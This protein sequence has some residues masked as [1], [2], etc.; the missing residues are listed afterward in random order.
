MEQ[1][2]EHFRPQSYNLELSISRQKEKI[3][4]KVEIRGFVER[5][6]SVIK[7]H[8]VNL[9]IKSLKLILENHSD[10]EF[11]ERPY[12]YDGEVLIIPLDHAVP[13]SSEVTV[14]IDYETKLNHNMQGCYL[15]TYEWQGEEQRIVA[16][17]FESH[18]AREA[19]PCIDEPAAK[20]I[21]S[22]T[23][24]D[25]DHRS[26]DIVIANTPIAIQDHNQFKFQ[27]TPPMSPYLL[28]WVIGPF[29]SV[30]SINGQGI[31]VTSYCALN[32]ST[33]SLLFANQAAE[34][35]LEYYEQQFGIEYPLVKLDQVALP[36]FEAG[37]M[38]NWGL[39]TY[40]ESMMLIDQNST[41][42]NRRTVATTVTHELSHQWFGNL[43]TMQWWDDLW[44]NESFATIMEYYCADQLYPELKVWYDFFAGDCIAALERDALRD[45]Q[46]VKQA[47]KH[48]DEIATLF[49]PAIVYAKGARLIYML[50]RLMGE[51]KF[52]QGIHDYFER[53]Q[54]KNT[55]GDDLW[56]C[57][58]P[59]AEFD[60]E[61]FMHAWITQ[62]GF[63]A[64]RH[65]QNDD[66]EQWEQQRFLLDGT[67]DASRWPLPEVFDD[68]S[69]HYL[70][71]LDTEDFQAKLDRL[72]QLTVEQKIRLL[73]DGRL[74]AEAEHVPAASLLELLAWFQTETAAPIWS[75]LD[76]ILS[77]LE[78]FFPPDST[79]RQDFRQFI[80]KLI[81]QPLAKLG[82]A[83]DT[84][85]SDEVN[86]RVLLL[87]LACFA[88]DEI[89]MRELA[90][91]YQP[92]LTA[93]PTE[94]L[95]FVLRSKLYLAEQQDDTQYFD[96]LYQEFLR[97]HHPKIKA[98]LRRVL[99]GAKLPANYQRMLELLE[100]TKTV[101]PQDHVFLFVCLVRNHYTKAQALDW[102]YS[103]W[104]F[105]LEL[106]GEKSLE[107]YLEYAASV[108]RT[109]S[110]AAAFR[111]FCDTKADQPALQ[112]TIKLAYDTIS[113]RLHLLASQT[114]AVRTKLA[115][116]LA[117]S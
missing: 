100:D 93:I 53:F 65:L 37:A 98:D 105:V 99:S 82:I 34:R 48:P 52:L 9:Q 22:L 5:G 46:S 77:L 97:I 86:L 50:V 15:S 28:A 90:N 35:T 11:A 71:D 117:G 44:L 115:E 23:L 43:V 73:T 18:Y 2:L 76:D 3:A 36:D 81:H 64:L 110:E 104:D 63:P 61:Q 20:A 31:L 56:T 83:S 38:E 74:L 70:L 92:E 29:R 96:Q 10:H 101:R 33:E 85:N 59:Y 102:L 91:L 42:A 106:N 47:V 84:Q 94:L 75:V 80:R 12:N 69:G 7:F 67:T 39:I 6:R 78:I 16:T 95:V 55:V 19:F 25:L 103:H 111:A 13:D 17:Q 79:E 112:R 41:L 87:A 32:H 57:L 4:G 27:D 113:H 30:S 45:V 1:F 109:E 72:D 14:L 54:F 68:M 108:I 8:G 89:V 21:F 40:R 24:I 66:L 88:Q 49:D 51:S 114:D 62:P 58:K 107:S 116:L 60:V 26:T